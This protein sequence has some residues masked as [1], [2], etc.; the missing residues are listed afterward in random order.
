MLIKTIMRYHYTPT[1]KA[2]TQNT[3]N[4]NWEACGETETQGKYKMLQPLW[5]RVWQFLIKLNI[6]FY[7]AKHLIQ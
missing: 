3:D 1:R 6:L 7:K 2:K 4:K 5:K